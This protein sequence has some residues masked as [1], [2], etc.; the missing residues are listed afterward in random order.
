MRCRMTD[1]RCRRRNC[2]ADWC[3]FGA[4]IG[5]FGAIRDVATAVTGCAPG[6]TPA[7]ELGTPSSSSVLVAMFGV[8]LVSPLLAFFALTRRSM[9]TSTGSATLIL[10]LIAEVLAIALA[11]GL[12]G[13]SRKHA[14][15]A[16]S[17]N[18]PSSSGLAW[19]IKPALFLF[20]QLDYFVKKFLFLEQNW[21][22]ARLML[23][24]RLVVDCIVGRHS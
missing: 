1:F 14:S 6:N 4:C 17:Q 20:P 24:E 18:Q 15:P 11:I 5:L 16:K 2:R 19:K 7:D 23:T 10:A 9:E 13:P 22:L 21:S 8:L 3:H 12:F